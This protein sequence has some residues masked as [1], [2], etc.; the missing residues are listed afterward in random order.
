M[1]YWVPTQRSTNV[2]FFVLHQWTFFYFAL[3]CLKTYSNYT[4]VR[5]AG[6]VRLFCVVLVLPGS[7]EKLYIFCNLPHLP[8]K[9][10]FL[11]PTLQKLQAIHHQMRYPNE[12]FFYLRRHRTCALEIWG[13]GTVSPETVNAEGFYLL[14]LA[15]FIHSFIH[16]FIWIRQLG[17]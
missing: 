5:T 7:V 14:F 13:G 10:F 16:S 2:S 15:L 12:T 1:S 11:F 9:Y 6:H 17:P 3:S 4:T 8:A